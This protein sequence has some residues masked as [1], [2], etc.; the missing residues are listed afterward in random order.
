MSRLLRLLRRLGRE[1]RGVAAVEFALVMP[2]LLVLYLGG[3]EMENCISTDR[4]LTL[5]TS[6][7]ANVTS[8]YTTMSTAD[9]STVLNASAQIMTPYSTQNL[10]IVLSEVQTDAT[11]KATV[12]WSK[13]FG[14]ATA[15]TATKPVT[16]PS[17]LA[18]PNVYYVMVQT[19]YAYA[20]TVGSGFFP[21]VP[22]SSQ[23]FIL[24]RQ[25][26]S[27]TYTGT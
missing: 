10:S 25:S 6:E 5:T 24:P 22:L 13:A 12:T 7:L 4:K 20:P 1:R 21:S 23:I 19:A 9:V 27:I 18:V 14:G 8:Q 2:M 26:S 3:Y 17:G 15:L 16:I 11:G